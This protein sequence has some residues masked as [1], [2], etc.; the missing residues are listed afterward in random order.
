MTTT[1]VPVHEPDTNTTPCDLVAVELA[2]LGDT[3]AAVAASL[4]AAGAVGP[5]GSHVFCPL[6]VYLYRV[7]GSCLQ[8]DNNQVWLVDENGDMSNANRIW[9]PY[10]VREFVVAF[11][12]GYYSELLPS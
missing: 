6:A 11:D 8:V 12:N 5:R 2:R 3:A 4:R 1:L 10:G 9:L 7:T